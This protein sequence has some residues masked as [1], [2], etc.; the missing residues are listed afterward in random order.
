MRILIGI[1]AGI[2]AYKIPL[3]I[4]LFIKSGAEVRCIMTPEA[5]EFVS[6]LVISTLSKNPV[7]IDFWNKDSGEWNNHI[8][9][10]EW[11]DVF[12]IAPCTANTLSKMAYGVCDNLLLAVYLSMRNKT[13]VFPAMDLEMYQHPTVKRNLSLLTKDRVQVIPPD[14]GELA[15]GL[16]GEG[17]LPEPEFMFNE[18]VKSLSFGEDFLNTQVLVT[19]GPTYE[20]I[21]PVRFIGNH[22]SGKMG[23]ALAENFAKRGASVTLITGPT[24]LK[25]EH[26][27]INTIHVTSAVEMFE[28]VRAHWIDMDLGVFS[29]AVADYRP[30]NPA[31]EKIKK[32]MESLSIEL[33]KNPDILAWAGEHKKAS[34]LT[35][36]FALETNNAMENAMEKLSRK[37]ADAIVLNVIEENEKCFNSDTN[38]VRIFDVNGLVLELPTASKARIAQ[39]IVD[40]IIRIRR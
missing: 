28:A 24:A 7:G 3:L 10:G 11:A 30:L 32:S 8:D 12:I 17:R 6:P 2:A 38:K 19:A 31:G 39:G 35:I 26:N 20:A 22:A 14:H 29:A 27:G 5:K 18:V 36:G 15:S 16:S 9:Y 1:T 40:F 25:A 23:F 37:N 13:I 33:I 34:Q 21:D 4:R